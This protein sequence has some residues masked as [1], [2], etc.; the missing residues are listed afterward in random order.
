M[1]SFIIVGYVWQILGRGELFAS[2]PPDPWAVSKMPVLNRVKTI[3]F[4]W[5]GIAS[6]IFQNKLI[7]CKHYLLNRRGS[8]V[9][10]FI[11]PRKFSV[12]WITS[13]IRVWHIWIILYF[14]H[15]RRKNFKWSATSFQY[16]LCSSVQ[17][18]FSS[19]VILLF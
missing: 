7:C 17:V 9:N 8:I 2:P 3:N 5:G 19:R 12:L 10:K 6:A 11:S 18:L 4:F 14:D 1:P 16:C 13:G 15:Y